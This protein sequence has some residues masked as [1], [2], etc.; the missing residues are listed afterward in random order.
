MRNLSNAAEGFPVCIARQHRQNSPL[1][2]LEAV[3]T[4]DFEIHSIS[5]FFPPP[6]TLITPLPDFYFSSKHPS[7]SLKYPKNPLSSSKIHSNL[8]SFSSVTKSQ[9]TLARNTPEKFLLQPIII[10]SSGLFY[11]HWQQLFVHLRTQF[12]I[13]ARFCLCLLCWIAVKSTFFQSAWKNLMGSVKARQPQATQWIRWLTHISETI[14]IRKWLLQWWQ[15][16]PESL[17]WKGWNTV[18][19]ANSVW[20]IW[21]SSCR[22]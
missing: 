15:M 1:F 3:N 6:S 21:K 9:L 22:W 16:I 13:L 7:S 11:C 8:L 10:R 19:N 4:A 18:T 14:R 20:S 17:S 5:C 2:V 12:I